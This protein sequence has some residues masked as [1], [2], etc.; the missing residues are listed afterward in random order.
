MDFM[1]DGVHLT[2]FGGD[3]TIYY[4]GIILMAGTMAGGWLASRE[5]T[6]R[7]HDPEIVWDMLIWLVIGGVIGARLWHVFTPS[8]S[9][10]ATGITTEYYLT[11]PFDL[12]NLRAGGLGVPGGIMGGAVALFFYVR[13]HKKPGFAEWVDVIAPS[14]A[15]GQ[16]I[17]R[18]GNF[19]NQELYGAPTD[20][21]W[22]ISID[23]LHRLAGFQEVQYYHP[24]FLYESLWNLAN[25]FFLIWIMRKFKDVLKTGDVFLVY[26]VT[27]PIGRFF[28]DFLRL[29]ASQLGGINANQTFAAI[30]ALVSAAALFW[31]HR[32]GK[33]VN[34]ELVD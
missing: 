29:D 23:P 30:V 26:L 12:I 1:F 21:P 28:L 7:G 4:Y 13:R 15:L 2:I 20:L 33:S 11:H 17:G 34:Q 3:F 16:A 14:L 25:M 32:A 10:I 9:S 19:F 22:K 31:R 24:L 27:Y 18:W 5:M 8:P 6:R